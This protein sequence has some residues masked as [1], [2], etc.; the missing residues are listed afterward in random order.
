ME[1]DDDTSAAR[2]NPNRDQVIEIPVP[3]IVTEDLAI[4]AREQCHRNMSQ[5]TRNATHEYLLGGGLLRCGECAAS[6]AFPLSRSSSLSE[7][8]ELSAP[9]V[10]IDW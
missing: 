10:L 7:R 5:A 4:R 9:S 8:N 2:V 1:I 6:R 3:A